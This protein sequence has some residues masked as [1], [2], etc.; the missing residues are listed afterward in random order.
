MSAA[1]AVDEVRCPHP[2]TAAAGK[3]SDDSSLGMLSVRQRKEKADKEAK[4]RINALAREIFMRIPIFSKER[5]YETNSSVFHIVVN[6]MG[7][8]NKSEKEKKDWW[9]NS[10]KEV[11]RT[12]HR[13]KRNHVQKEV[14]KKMTGEWNVWGIRLGRRGMLVGR[15]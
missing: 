13:K 4:K 1:A 6:G 15:K 9:E 5:Q 2:V 14:C 7:H 8:K 3:V 10:Y 12:A 11:F